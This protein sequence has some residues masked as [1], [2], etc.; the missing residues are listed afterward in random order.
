MKK[1]EHLIISDCDDEREKG[2]WHCIKIEGPDGSERVD[3]DFI[4]VVNDLGA[5]GWE[6]VSVLSRK[7]LYA[8]IMK[9]EAQ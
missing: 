1:W 5:K 2:E 9:R 4:E 3:K 6:A 8:A 7:G